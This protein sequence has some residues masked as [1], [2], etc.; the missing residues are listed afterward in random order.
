MI[1][2]SIKSKKKN[3]LND[4]EALSYGDRIKRVI[5]LSHDINKEE[6]KRLLSSLLDNNQYEANL[7]LTGAAVIRDMDIIKKSLGH[8]KNSIR[9]KASKLL[10]KYALAEEIENEIVNLSYECRKMIINTICS[11]NNREAA[12]R[13]FPI[14]YTKYG[15]LEARKLFNLCSHETVKKYINEVGYAIYHWD[16]VAVHHEEIFTEYFKKSLEKS[17]G[18]ERT[19]KWYEFLDG[20]KVLAITNADFLLDLAIEYPAKDRMYSLLFNNLGVLARKNPS[21]LCNIICSKE[22]R[23]ELLLYGI[24]KCIISNNS[25]T[26]QQLIE[27]GKILKNE[28]KHIK[29]IL[30]AL[31]PSRREEFFVSVYDE[32]E[33][34]KKIFDV[35]ILEELPHNLRN[36]VAKNMLNNKEV[37]N[38]KNKYLSIL[39]CYDISLSREK[40]EKEATASKAEERS[41]ALGLI[42]KNTAI[43]KKEVQMTLSYLCR[44][45]NDQDPVRRE[46][47]EELSKYNPLLFHDEDVLSLDIIS[48][49]VIEARDTSYGTLEYLGKLAFNILSCTIDKEDSELFKFSQGVL[50]CISKRR[51][52]LALYRLNN[53]KKKCRYKIFDVFYEFLKDC[54]N[55]ENYS[56]TIKMADLLAEDGYKIINL[57]ELLKE[58]VMSKD[59]NYSRQ[60]TKYYLADPKE[61]DNRVEMLL[62][63]DN[64]FIS[65]N[66][67]FN[68]IHTKRQEL[69]DPY[70]KGNVIKGKFLTGKTIYLVPATE[71]FYKYLPYQQR[72]FKDLL[73]RVVSEKTY[74]Y[75]E[76]TKAL[77]AVA[78]M[79]DIDP[80][81]LVKLTKGN[82]VPI[83]ESALH[84]ISAIDE[85]KK[86]I[87]TL[88]DN[89]DGDK[90]RV[91]MY[92]L[93]KCIKRVEPKSVDKAIYDILKK[94]KLKITVKKE[95]I[96]LLGEYKSDDNMKLLLA[97]SQKENINKDVQIA[98]GAATLK[99]LDYEFAWTSLEKMIAL[100]ESNAIR[101]LL[102]NYPENIVPKHRDKYLNLILKIAKSDDNEVSKEALMTMKKWVSI[103]PKLI[104]DFAY[105]T[106]IDFKNN[107]R[108]KVSLDLL[109]Y[110][111]LYYDMSSYLL[112]GVK[113]LADIK[114]TEAFNAKA[115]RDIP[116]IQRLTLL[117]NKL[118]NSD[119]MH[120]RKLVPLFEEMIDVIERDKTSVKICIRLYIA[121]MDF[122]DTKNVVKYINCISQ[123]IKERPYM[124]EF[125][126]NEIKKSLENSKSYYDM[127]NLIKEA[128]EI[129]SST[130][131][132]AMYLSLALLELAGKNMLWTEECLEQLRILRNSSDIEVVS[133]AL[134]IWTYLE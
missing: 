56:C 23:K 32:N 107:T 131:V 48:K 33:I 53:I 4:L 7:A 116:H 127:E 114:I 134:D 109:I 125:A 77:H 26:M 31:K 41:L 88:L 28:N 72:I 93:S 85:P 37:I 133:K 70:I 17:R 120:K 71:E 115:N 98:I 18:Q 124:A 15:I 81:Y 102:S 1:V 122:D 65:V 67:V 16:K 117:I 104:A 49:S 19:Y 74:S 101:S 92:S 25:I 87:E 6:Y 83:I 100:K 61:R 96:R 62:N 66:E 119:Q 12:E 106:L 59:A 46:V 73:K 40:L 105:N 30:H 89:L 118:I 94:D 51:G 129:I 57:Q 80:Y 108:W 3:F 2:N 36:N 82:E 43:N 103:N 112:K 20:A 55:R 128:S 79:P 84:A 5:S 91:S 52:S 90:A 68:H 75:Y 60:A 47:L 58:A 97:Q 42:A 13:L 78:N 121:C 44:I 24:P 69:L 95:A 14:I 9:L 45:K 8:D 130:F 126:Y 86:A 34:N 110:E 29:N 10:A 123:I 99:Y 111:A 35:K 76:R 39:A 27:I 38:D 21:K 22:C 63:A 64:S 50:L 11:S 54:N 113:Y 132:Q